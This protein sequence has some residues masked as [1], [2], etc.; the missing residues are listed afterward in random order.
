MMDSPNGD[1]QVRTSTG[2]KCR[3]SVNQELRCTP[4]VLHD[5]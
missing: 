3:A 5:F 1:E 2:H 4:S